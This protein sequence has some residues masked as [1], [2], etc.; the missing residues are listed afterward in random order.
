MAIELKKQ[1]SLLSQIHSEMSVGSVVKHRE[2]QLWEAQRIVTQLKRKL[3][4]QPVNASSLSAKAEAISQ[5]PPV[6]TSAEPQDELRLE[7]A[8]PQSQ[9]GSPPEEVEPVPITEPAK[10][11]VD[12][13]ISESGSPTEACQHVNTI[14][15]ESQEDV[16]EPPMKTPVVLDS[17]K[18]L[19][20]MLKME[21]LERET[22]ID[23]LQKAIEKERGSVE[24][25]QE[26]LA[27]TISTWTDSSDEEETTESGEEE[28]QQQILAEIFRENRQLEEQN[29]VLQTQIEEARE[30]CLQYRVQLRVHD[31]KIQ[32]GVVSV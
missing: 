29:V 10:E 26:L 18:E 31:E 22:A 13:D 3:R 17:E 9:P 2:E 11:P 21:N 28:Q 1:E 19:E 25:L 12:S 4:H 14:E 7:L 24:R 8:L 23:Q 32:L 16:T 20:L 5:T 6:E 30:A 15:A 27:E